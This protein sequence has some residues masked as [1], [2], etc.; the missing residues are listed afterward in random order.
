MKNIHF[1]YWVIH[2][3]FNIKK[4]VDQMKTSENDYKLIYTGIFSSLYFFISFL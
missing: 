4:L 1:K 3:Y 2:I